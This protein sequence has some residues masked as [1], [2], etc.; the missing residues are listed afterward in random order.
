MVY[1]QGTNFSP[2]LQ[3]DPIVPCDVLFNL[4]APDGSKRTAQG[5]ADSLG[6]FTSR[7]KW[8]LDQPGVWTYTIS[9][10]WNGFNG[11]VPGLPDQGGYIFVL[12]NG[13]QSGPGITLNLS[14]EQTFS[15][16]EGL[17][18]HGNSS[19]SEVFFA[20]ITP[21]AVL[22]EGVIP[23]VDGQFIYKFDPKKMAEKIM[24]Y[25]IM[26]LVNGK[27]EIGRIVH[28]TFFSEE[29]GPNGTYHSFVR[30]VLRGTKAIYLKDPWDLL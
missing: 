11:R 23:V 14:E 21:G 24:T 8:P 2:V 13:S 3:I 19:A 29:M 9:A 27:P 15:P 18:I 30:V 7:E 10:T 28:L 5:T 17:E 25:D 6:Y 22:E 26:N 12:E 16:A 4:T 20:A 1:L